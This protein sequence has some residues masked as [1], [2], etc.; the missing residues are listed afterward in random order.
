MCEINGLK[1]LLLSIQKLAEN[2]P[3]PAFLFAFASFEEFVKGHMI[4]ENWD[5]EYISHSTCKNKMI[6]HK[7]KLKKGKYLVDKSLRDTAYKI[8]KEYNVPSEVFVYIPENKIDDVFVDKMYKHRTDIL[9]VNYDFQNNCWLPVKEETGK[10]AH[11][12]YNL[13]IS[14]WMLIRIEMAK[15]KIKNINYKEYLPKISHAL[16]NLVSRMSREH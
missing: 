9:Y 4:L 7:E 2:D 13:S 16:I 12:M 11:E 10:M 15:L 6:I 3:L 8:M 1:L 14:S 5:K